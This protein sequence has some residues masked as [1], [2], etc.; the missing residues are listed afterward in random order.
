MT[1]KFHFVVNAQPATVYL[2]LGEGVA[3]NIIF[4]CLFLKIHK[5]SIMTAY[6]ALVSGILKEKFKMEM[7]VPQ[8]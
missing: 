5:A 6:N 4:S 7:M 8:R 3:C 1:L 2:S